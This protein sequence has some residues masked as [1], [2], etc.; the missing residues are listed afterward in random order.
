MPGLSNSSNRTY[1]DDFSLHASESSSSLSR[2]NFQDFSLPE[3]YQGPSLFL[4]NLFPEETICENL[5]KISSAK[6]TDSLSNI[7]DSVSNVVHET[8]NIIDMLNF[9]KSK[10][11]YVSN[12]CEKLIKHAYNTQNEKLDEV[13]EKLF[14][15]LQNAG[16]NYGKR[17][18]FC[19]IC[20][21]EYNNEEYLPHRFS[22]CGH[23]VC[24][25]CCNKF[26]Q[27]LKC[28][29][30]RIVNKTLEPVFL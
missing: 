15:Q 14:E 2:M 11:T 8:K 10:S 4:E 19:S 7:L 26:M 13:M 25:I 6:K 24:G 28:P 5:P 23:C 18:T 1:C 30:C 20:Y 9:Y 27:N 21:E 29:I 3:I 17:I 16:Y 12:L 22:I